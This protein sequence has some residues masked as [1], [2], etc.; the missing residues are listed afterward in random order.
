MEKMIRQNVRYTAKPIKNKL[1]EH[2]KG[3]IKAAGISLEAIKT[4]DPIV[5]AVGVSKKRFTDLMQ[6]GTEWLLCEAVNYCKYFKINISEYCEKNL[7][8]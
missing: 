4:S 5:K 1:P 7:S 6:P 2:F 3:I 8:K